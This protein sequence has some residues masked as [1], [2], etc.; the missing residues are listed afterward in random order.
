MPGTQRAAHTSVLARKNGKDRDNDG[1]ILENERFQKAILLVDDCNILIVSEKL[2]PPLLWALPRLVKVHTVTL[3]Y[4]D[5]FPKPYLQH[6]NGRQ[7]V[8]PTSDHP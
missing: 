2:A 8:F 7:L 1:P 3:R 4:R 6:P 5:V